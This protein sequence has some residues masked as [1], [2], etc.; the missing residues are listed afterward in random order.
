MINDVHDKRIIALDDL[1]DKPNGR[2]RPRMKQD[3]CR[4]VLLTNFELLSIAA[5]YIDS[6]KMNS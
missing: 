5:S 4:I 6:I 1:H 2:E 3:L